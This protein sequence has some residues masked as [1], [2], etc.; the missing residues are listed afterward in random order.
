M[1]T[2]ASIAVRPFVLATFAVGAVFA[3]RVAA[4][5][6]V[7]GFDRVE[8]HYDATQRTRVP[9][10]FRGMV[11]GYM[12]AG[13]WA[14]GQLQDNYLSWKT[15]VVPTRQATTFS[16]IGATTVLPSQFSRGP[17]AKLSINSHYA[18]TF[19]IGMNRD[20]TWKEGDYQLK[21][22]SKRVEFPY[23]GA[24]RQG[25]LNGNSGIFQL[26]V[27]ADAVVPGQPALLKVE[28]L[29]FAEWKGGWFM[30]KERRDTLKQSTEIRE[31]EIE[32]LRQ[33]MAVM[34]EQMQI[35]ATQVYKDLSGQEKFEHEVIYTDK[36]RHLHPADLIRLQN[37]DLLIMA[38]EASEHYA[39][40]GDV[41][42]LRSKDGGKTWG[43][44]QVIGGIKD[45]DEREGCGVQLRDG[46]IIV[47]I[48]YNGNYNPD[49]SYG[50]KV[51][52]PEKG[53]L[54]TYVITSA[55][56]G[57]TWSAPNYIDTKGMPFTGTEGPT[58]APIEMPDGTLLMGVIGYHLDGDEK[59]NG[60]VMLRSADQGRSWRYLSTIASDDGG[61]MGGLA[62]PG[63]VRTKTGRIIAGIR[64]P[65]SDNSI[66]MT[67]SDDD[68]KTWVPIRKTD[69]HGHPVDLIQLSDGRVMA[70][71]GIRVPQH[72]TPGGI[73]ACF[74]RDNG[75]TWDIRSE[76]QLRNDF[77]NWDVGYPESIQLPDGRVFTAYYY[78]LFGRYFLGGTFWEP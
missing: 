6:W 19:A 1:H 67:W 70:T 29:P 66:Y 32:A 63:I 77:L 39:P 42:L 11:P 18:L 71:Y 49:G 36:F 35:L 58:D 57:H 54:G 45:L 4:T 15:A 13:W 44:K 68:G 60:S 27:P 38:R 59:N 22:I 40:D 53:Y 56:N 25:E 52:E 65:G 9:R 48:F 12:T 26:S 50:R 46:T 75:E 8:F 24:S 34:Q 14:P 47:G 69:L 72:D 30:V 31:G 55:D 20:F 2:V 17:A 5:Q 37:G 78:N 73:R 28:I 23:F 3:S 21:Y 62:E 16:F 7:E 61:K 76:V 41:I 10:D 33:D 64:T 51:R 74:S 43:E